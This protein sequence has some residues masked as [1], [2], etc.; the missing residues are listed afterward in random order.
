MGFGGWLQ[1]IYG[2]STH[3]NEG[4]GVKPF[5]GMFD[6]ERESGFKILNM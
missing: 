1:L 5:L 3:Q 4:V 2:Q 6:Y